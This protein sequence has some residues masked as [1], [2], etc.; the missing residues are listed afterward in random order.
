M[1]RVSALKGLLVLGCGLVLGGALDH[2]WNDGIVAPAAAQERRAALPTAEE[3]PGEV[4][5]LKALV[6]SNSHIMMDV[7]FQW[8]SL[9]FAGQQ[10]N[11]PLAQYFFSEGRNHIR[12]LVTKSPTARLRDGTMVDLKSIFDAIDTSSLAAVKTAIDRKNSA[13]FVAAYRATLESCYAC[14]KAA[15]RP[16]LRPMVPQPGSPSIINYDPNASWP[17]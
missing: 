11:W 3:M 17:K 10:R 16:Y 12:W 4:A 15:G 6:P 8:M 5:R 1:R 7:Q 14:H 9:W 2:A 13:E